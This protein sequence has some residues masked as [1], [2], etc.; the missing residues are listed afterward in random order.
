ME[1]S[2]SEIRKY[3]LAKKKVEN[4]KAF[5]IHA[6]VFVLCMPIII[7]T[8]FMFVPGFHFFWLALL[9]WGIGLG[10]H[11]FVVFGENLFFGKE[12]EARKT[13]EFMKENDKQ[14]WE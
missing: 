7:V 14:L 10:I 4:I 1:K 3:E 8:N 2:Y 11:G 5:Y 9:G 12:W 6:L 13:K